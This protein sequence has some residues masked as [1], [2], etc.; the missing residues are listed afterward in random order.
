MLNYYLLDRET[1]ARALREATQSIS[2]FMAY[3]NHLPKLRTIYQRGAQ[4]YLF[5]SFPFWN[6]TI[7][8]FDS[9]LFKR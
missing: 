4:T 6:P 9:L 5:F 2:P 7:L 3:L 8:K 1:V